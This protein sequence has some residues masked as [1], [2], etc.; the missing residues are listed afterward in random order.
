MLIGMDIGTTFK[1]VLATLGGSRDMRRTAVAHVAY[2][3]V[4][5]ALAFLVVG[6][7]PAALTQRSEAVIAAPASSVRADRRE[8]RRGPETDR[9]DD[10]DMMGFQAVPAHRL[11]ALP[12][13]ALAPSCRSGPTS[14]PARDTRAP[15]LPRRL[16]GNTP[17]GTG[18]LYP[19]GPFPVRSDA[20]A[21][22]PTPPFPAVRTLSFASFVPR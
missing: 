1:S 5:G 7:A 16:R 19:P 13:S 4:T 8:Q 21:D 18:T 20:A 9:S 22:Q 14:P 15:L 11:P 6:W 3:I 12:G 2:N 10:F 17:I